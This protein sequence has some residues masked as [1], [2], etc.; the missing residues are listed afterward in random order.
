MST[1]LD[2][3]YQKLEEAIQ[4]L[5]LPDHPALLY[6][7]VKYTLSDPGKR[8]RSKLTLLGAVLTGGD[9]VRAIPAGI[10][11]ELLHNFT[12]IH[13]DIMDNADTRRGKLTVY[14]KWGVPTAILSGDILFGLSYQQLN[15][16]AEQGWLTASEFLAL[17][18]TFQEAVTAVCEGQALD[19]EFECSEMVPIQS[20]M[21]MIQKKTAALISAAIEMGG[22]ATNASLEMRSH[23]KAMGNAA[24]IAFQ[25]QDDLMDVIADPTSFG[26]KV[27]GDIREGKKTWLM[28]RAFERAATQDVDMLRQ[29]CASKS[30]NEI[31]INHVIRL[32]ENLGILKDAQ[33]EIEHYYN[34][35][36]EHLMV[37]K[38][39]AYFT[40]TRTFFDALLNRSS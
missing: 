11:M 17:L 39:S 37:F 22:I 30:A 32:Y 26:K 31:Q 6:Q 7:P 35:A 10:A 1:H 4:S 24:G 36:M 8:I 19:I 28:I 20:Y 13:D 21:L 29:I 15:V 27:G 23:L 33:K 9:P 14:R 5:P 40:Y 38:E 12:L 18:R 25:I 3:L 34:E 2:P 16:Y